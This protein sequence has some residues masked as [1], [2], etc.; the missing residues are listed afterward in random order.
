VKTSDK[1]KLKVL[2]ARIRSLREKQNISQAQ[3]AY[4]CE[5]SREYIGLVERGVYSPTITTLWAIADALS[6]SV[7][8]LVSSK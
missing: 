5:L 1:K 2:G 3:L 6:I 4:E 7:E 8:E